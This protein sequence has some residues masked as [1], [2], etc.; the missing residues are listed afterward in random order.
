MC[1]A[2]IYYNLLCYFSDNLQNSMKTLRG[3]TTSLILFVNDSG[4]RA[5]ETNTI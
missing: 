1:I 3:E 5:L 4:E 2:K